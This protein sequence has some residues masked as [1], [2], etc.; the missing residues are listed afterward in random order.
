MKILV[1]ALSGIGDALMFT[2]SLVKIHDDIPSADI[3]ALVMYK[4]VKDI[5]DKLP[6]ISE[7][8]Y[9]N[10]LNSSY[11]QAFS[12]VMSLRK[13]YDVTINVY[14]SNRKEYN[15][16][17]WMLGAPNR[18]A[19]K[20]LRKD[21]TNLGF[22]NNIRIEEDDNLHNVEENIKL[23]ER[24]SKIEHKNISPLR[25]N[26]GKDDL[27]FAE[28]FLAEK[29]ITGDLLVAGFHPGCSTLKNHEKRRW[30]VS[31]FAELGKRLIEEH[32]AKI[33]VFG[34]NDERAVK[35]SVTAGINSGSAFTVN[36]DSVSQTAAVMKRCNVF[37]TNDS[38]LMHIA[39]A[40]KLKVVA[41]IGPTNKNYI[42][43][44]QTDFK[45]AS[46]NLDCSPC[47]YYSPKPLTCYRKDVKFKCIK[48]LS[49]DLVLRRVKEFIERKEIKSR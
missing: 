48:E 38:S 49:V 4:G 13:K 42:Y 31:K 34:G 33:L 43:P 5:Y 30:E 37:V 27:E 19:V 1:I 28:R 46:L 32:N 47:F 14:P 15:L 24:L 39:A 9:F 11:L 25:L 45:I 16:I 3:D 35:D 12:Y 7:T 23:C 17:S 26:L 2:P 22:L 40:L 36:T 44:W 20:Y 10:F 8:K 21:F 18:I 6:Q 29:K 41:I